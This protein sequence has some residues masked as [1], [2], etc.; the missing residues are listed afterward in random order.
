MD[1]YTIIAGIVSFVLGIGA[2]AP[3]L[4]K[5]KKGLHIAKEALD[6]PL[7]LRTA[8]DNLEKSLADG[9]LD[10]SEV[11][12]IVKDYKEIVKQIEEVKQ[13]L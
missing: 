9:Q 7:A 6:V 3:Y 5:I 8:I 12:Q 10:P 2:V 11:E 4:S 13:L 1:L